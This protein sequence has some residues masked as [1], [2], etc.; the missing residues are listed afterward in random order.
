[1][2][3]RRCGPSSSAER[4]PWRPIRSSAAVAAAEM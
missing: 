4:R 3:G 2:S 1:M